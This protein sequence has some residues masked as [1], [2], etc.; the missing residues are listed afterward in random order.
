MN[1]RF[2]AAITALLMLSA[3][4]GWGQDQKI[5]FID[6]DKSFNSLNKT[7]KGHAKVEEAKDEFKQEVDEMEEQLETLLAEQDA[8]A[9]EAL[10]PAVSEE[11]REARRDEGELKAVEIREFRA[12][13]NKLFQDRG[14]Q[15]EQQILRMRQDIIDEVV[16]EARVYARDEGYS[17]VIDVS[18]MS[19]NQVPV[20]L[21]WDKAH[22]ITDAIVEKIN[23][24]D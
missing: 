20:V 12:K 17:A 9:E 5:A 3:L 7:K 22:D 11:I 18:S 16:E 1:K 14:R 2:Y 15:L 4:P 23:G 10:S 19:I 6:L 21:Y 24:R 13:K 8:I